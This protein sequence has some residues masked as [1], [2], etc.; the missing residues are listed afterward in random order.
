MS[1][2]SKGI[3]A[4]RELIHLFWKNNWTAIRTAGSGS[5]KYPSPDIVAGNIIRKL[6]IECKAS[7]NNSIYLLQEDID[8]IKTYAALFGAEAWFGIRFNNYEWYF[9]SLDDIQQT[10]SNNYVIATDYIKQ[11]GLLFEE[12]IGKF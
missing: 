12:L 8:Q 1:H 6:A 10:K 3:N 4:E 5:N 11:K 7:K 2:K 9:L